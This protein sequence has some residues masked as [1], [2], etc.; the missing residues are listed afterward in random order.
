MKRREEEERRAEAAVWLPQPGRDP[1]RS[2]F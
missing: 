1:V 2:S